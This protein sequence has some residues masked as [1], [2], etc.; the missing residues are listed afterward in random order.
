MGLIE[1]IRVGSNLLPNNPFNPL[2]AEEYGIVK[3]KRDLENAEKN[4]GIEAY[5][6]A[7]FL[8]QQAVEKFLKA[9]W[10]HLLGKAPPLTRSL[11]ELGR[12]LNPPPNIL[13]KLAY[14]TPDYVISRYPNAANAIPFEIY[15]EEIARSKVRAAREVIQWLQERMKKL[16]GS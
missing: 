10:M 15:D 6:V 13:K 5:E 1:R 14:L 2:T 8:S 16:R 11:P 3:I 12:A 7:A 4:I 9:A